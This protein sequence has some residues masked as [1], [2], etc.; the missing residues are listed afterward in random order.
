MTLGLR[1]SRNRRRRRRI[2]TAVKILLVLAVI[3]ALGFYAYQTGSSLAARDVT[4]LREEVAQLTATNESLVAENSQLKRELSTA[5]RQAAD[6]QGRYEREV[7]TGEIKTLTD[8]VAE[9]ARSGVPIERLEFLINASSDI[10]A[11]DNNPETKRFIVPTPLYRGANSWVGFADSTITVTAEGVSAKNAQGQ[12]EAWY[13]PAE[14]VTLRFTRLG[15][16]TT[17]ISGKLPLHHSVLVGDSEYRF[18]I[19][20][21]DR[22]FITV[23]GDRCK[24]P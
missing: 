17:E 3:G 5:K 7:P 18:T 20:A 10:G 11:C 23:T 1:D 22:G 8:L 12:V 19:A 13:D 4:V 24:F 21:G 14:P 16:E 15:G 9:K 6:W 2:W